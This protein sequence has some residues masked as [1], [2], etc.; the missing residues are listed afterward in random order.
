MSNIFLI[1]KGTVGT[2]RN[3]QKGFGRDPSARAADRD[4]SR[5]HTRDQSAPESLLLQQLSAI[6]SRTGPDRWLLPSPPL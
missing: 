1:D 2:C 6:I 3:Y 4:S 5:G